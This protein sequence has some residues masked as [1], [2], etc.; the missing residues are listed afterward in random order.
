MVNFNIASSAVHLLLLS[1]LSLLACSAWLTNWL[2]E[3]YPLAPAGLG[4]AALPALEAVSLLLC[5]GLAASLA[6]S[7]CGLF[8]SDDMLSSMRVFKL[9]AVPFV[10]IISFDLAV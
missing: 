7:T 6:A 2:L 1:K 9:C 3:W 5:C 4:A 8:I 10:Q